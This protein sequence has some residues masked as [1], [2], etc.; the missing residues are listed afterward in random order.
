MGICWTHSPF[1][2]LPLSLLLVPFYLLRQ[3]LSYFLV[4]HTGFY[5]P[6]NSAETTRANSAFWVSWT[7]KRPGDHIA[8]K[9]LRGAGALELTSGHYCWVITD[10]IIMVP[11]CRFEQMSHE[12]IWEWQR[13]LESYPTSVDIEENKLSPLK[14]PENTNSNG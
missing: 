6:I 12:E 10:T 11:S 4:I 3:F 2:F 9:F 13:S 8:T 14:S 7:Q 5:V 1:P